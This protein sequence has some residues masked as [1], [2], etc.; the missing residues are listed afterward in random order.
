MSN[1]LKLVILGP[2]EIKTTAQELKDA[3]E[4]IKA[5]DKVIVE[6]R[7]EIDRLNYIIGLKE[8]ERQDWAAM[9]IT[10]QARI[11]ELERLLKTDL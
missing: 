11:E 2:G 1:D 9:C 10:K 6:Q 7:K 8:K 3:E 4:T 5:Q